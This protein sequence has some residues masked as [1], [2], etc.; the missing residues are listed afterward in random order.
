MHSELY[1]NIY[2]MPDRFWHLQNLYLYK[3]SEN[4]TRIDWWMRRKYVFGY[5][6]SREFQ[7][8]LP[9]WFRHRT[10]YTKM[11]RHVL[12]LSFLTL[13]LLPFVS[14][15]V[16]ELRALIYRIDRFCYS[17]IHVLINF[18]SIYFNFLC[19][20]R[21]Y[22]VF[23]FFFCNERGPMWIDTTSLQ[24]QILFYCE[25]NMY[26]CLYRVGSDLIASISP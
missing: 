24:S 12:V 21:Y 3:L 10:K 20:L 8:Y 14:P 9:V 13:V 18:I 26:Q 7:I 22:N 19:R 6:T 15:F 25:S 16:N 1:L 5:Q 2:L 17:R 11:N 23:Y 4:L